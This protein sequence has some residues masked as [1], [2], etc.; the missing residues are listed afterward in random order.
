MKILQAHSPSHGSKESCHLLFSIHGKTVRTPLFGKIMRNPSESS[1]WIP[2]SL[3]LD[4]VSVSHVLCTLSGFISAKM[5]YIILLKDLFQNKVI[6]VLDQYKGKEDKTEDSQ[7]H[8]LHTT[9]ENVA[10]TH[11]H[12][13]NH[14][15]TPKHTHTHM[16]VCQFKVI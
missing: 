9:N 8:Q 11:A 13:H 7:C 14:K 16:A 4:V 15:H 5:G 1:Q 10:N 2:G 6:V 3:K 12:T